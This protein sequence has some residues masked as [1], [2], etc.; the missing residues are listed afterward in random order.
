MRFLGLAV[1]A[2]ASFERLVDQELWDSDKAERGKKCAK[3]ALKN[4]CCT[5]V[6]YACQKGAETADSAFPAFIRINNFI[7]FS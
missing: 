2:V 6:P 4:L 5:R 7:V 1:S 3:V